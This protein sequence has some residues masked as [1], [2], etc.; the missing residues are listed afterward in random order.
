MAEAFEI[1]QTTT[2]GHS[3]H[4][5]DIVEVFGRFWNRCMRL[6]PDDHYKKWPAFRSRICFA[7]NTAA[8]ES[9][10]KVVPHEIYFGAQARNAF[11]PLLIVEDVEN[12]DEV[13]LPA[14]MAE[15][16]KISTK[17]LMK[18]AASHD[19]YVRAETARR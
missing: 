5:N 12:I 18:M 16:V 13:D 8:H 10:S 4:S 14:K 17:A 6:L 3:A 19:Q 2:M 1:E 9:L 15:A 11:T 7:I